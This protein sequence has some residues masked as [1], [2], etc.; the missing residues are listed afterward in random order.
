MEGS[1]LAV[2]MEIGAPCFDATALGL[3]LKKCCK[4][5][6]SR[7]L[8]LS[9]VDKPSYACYTCAKLRIGSG[10]KNREVMVQA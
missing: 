1:T 2:G 5:L 8:R 7:I 4:M 10:F 6:R 3:N 9:Q